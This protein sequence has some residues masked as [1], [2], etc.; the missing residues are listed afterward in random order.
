MS[1][2]ASSP[3][4]VDATARKIL[5]VTATRIGDAVLSTGLLDWLTRRC[6]D[7][8]FT[9]ACGPLPAPLF[10]RHPRLERLVIMRKRPRGGHWL[11][12]WQA[13]RRDRWDLVV[14]L[15]RS[16]LPWLVRARHRA[17]PPGADD[18]LHR[19]ALIARTLNL[20]PPPAPVLWLTEID[21]ARAAEAL[22]PARTVLAV[23]PTSNWVAKTWPAERFAALVR[24]LIAPGAALEDA[25]VFVTGGPD[26]H[27]MIRPVL[28]ALPP[29]RLVARMGMDLP[30][31]AAV[32]RRTRL[33]IGND[34]GLMHLAAAAGA[35]TLGLFGPTRDIHYAPWGPHCRT[36]RTAKSV[37]EL[38]GAP[39][40]NHLTTGC[41]MDSLTVD[42]VEKAAKELLDSTRHLVQPGE[43]R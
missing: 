3:P 26:E 30:A 24:R 28:D 37:Q 6:P 11:D 15:R 19:V 31:T 2:A 13:V 35:P 4:P 10:E 20:D 25:T 41:L 33:F 32:F 34:S 8:R 29:E 7:A 18:E 23:A 40:F 9:I 27:G 21:H 38:I 14:D 17:V 42:D 1:T 22:G 36:V 39:D 43:E 16:L 5:F 12:L